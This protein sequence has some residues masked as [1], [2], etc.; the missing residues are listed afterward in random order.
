MVADALSK[1]YRKCFLKY[2][3]T[4]SQSF[5]EVRIK[6]EKFPDET[7]AAGIVQC[8]T[9]YPS[10]EQFKDPIVY[11]QS[12]Q[13]EAEQYGMCKIVPPCGWKVSCLYIYLK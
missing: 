7:E 10:E 5:G 9:Y 6:T 4:G 2:F 12:I 3:P 13:S 1:L 8:P 11:I